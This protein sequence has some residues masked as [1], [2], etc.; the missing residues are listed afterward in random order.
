MGKIYIKKWC[1]EMLN[2]DFCFKISANLR[3]HLPLKFPRQQE[4]MYPRRKQ[5]YK[6]RSFLSNLI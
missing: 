6:N 4:F 2:Y 3:G 5:V 1:T